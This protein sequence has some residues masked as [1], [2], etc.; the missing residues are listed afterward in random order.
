MTLLTRAAVVVTII[1][2]LSAPLLMAASAKA[3]VLAI[4]PGASVLLPDDRDG[5]R[6]FAPF[7][8]SAGDVPSKS[9]IRNCVLKMVRTGKAHLIHLC[10]NTRPDK[11]TC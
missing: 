2:A 6:A 11:P 4:D 5:A 7:D 10:T 3:D 9:Q 1:A 8:V